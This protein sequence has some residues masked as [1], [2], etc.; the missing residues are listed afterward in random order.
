MKKWNSPEL[1]VLNICE[2]AAVTADGFCQYDKTVRCIAN[3][4]G[5][6]QCNNCSYNP[7]NNKSNGTQERGE[8]IDGTDILS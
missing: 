1:L 4:K 8:E 2:T 5:P 3:G 6:G 7:N